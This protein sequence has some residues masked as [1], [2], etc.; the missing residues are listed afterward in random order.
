[1]PSRQVRQWDGHLLWWE[2]KHLVAGKKRQINQG[3]ANV[4]KYWEK[5]R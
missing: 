3:K 2:E 1:V 4:K 5:Q